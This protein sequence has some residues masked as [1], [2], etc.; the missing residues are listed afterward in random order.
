MLW[1][2]GVERSPSLRPREEEVAARQEGMARLS[3][4][5]R[6]R[7]LTLS[8]ASWPPRKLCLA[9]S[10]VKPRRMGGGVAG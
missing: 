1:W 7:V 8:A 2:V 6:G 4:I 9:G 10:F 5:A 3:V